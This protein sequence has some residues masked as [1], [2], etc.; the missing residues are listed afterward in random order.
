[1][2]P[3]TKNLPAAPA[4][5]IPA[6]AYI[7]GQVEQEA[8]NCE[9]QRSML[10]LIS[11]FPILRFKWRYMAINTKALA[12][13]TKQSSVGMND[14]DGVLNMFHNAFDFNGFNACL[15]F[16]RPKKDKSS[17]IKLELEDFNENEVEKYL[18][19]I[20]L[21]LGREHVFTS[22]TND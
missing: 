14:C 1:M 15:L 2:T 21:D 5:F 12:I 11:F 16:T 20:T 19:S 18:Q 22:V 8:K 7:S 6:L 4:Q 13:N 3:T 10:W 9:G 17:E